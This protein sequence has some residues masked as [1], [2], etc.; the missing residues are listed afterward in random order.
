MGRAVFD[1]LGLTSDELGLGVLIH[2][3]IIPQ[4]VHPNQDAPLDEFYHGE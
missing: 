1:E 3:P 2:D 4:V